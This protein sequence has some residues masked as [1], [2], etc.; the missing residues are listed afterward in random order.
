MRCTAIY[1]AFLG[2]VSFWPL[3]KRIA[4]KGSD[5]LWLLIAAVVLMI[6]DAGLDLI[7][8]RN[9]T[10]ASRTLTGSLLGFAV[11]WIT[12]LI[13]TQEYRSSLQTVNYG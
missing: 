4:A 7:G 8:M 3:L 1:L 12:S 2:A 11:G 10:L 6:V 13:A 5:V 9:S